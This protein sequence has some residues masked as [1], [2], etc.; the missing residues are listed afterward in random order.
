MIKIENFYGYENAYRSYGNYDHGDPQNWTTV[1]NDAIF[2][3]D[4]FSGLAICQDPFAMD[5]GFPSPRDEELFGVDLDTPVFEQFQAPMV[6]DPPSDSFSQASVP[7]AKADPPAPEFPSDWLLASE[8]YFPQP[9]Q[10]PMTIPPP[11]FI[12]AP[13]P[14]MNGPP[15]PSYF[16]QLPAAA[17]P[18]F[19]FKMFEPIPPAQKMINQSDLFSP[20]VPEE[21]VL[22]SQL[23]THDFDFFYPHAAPSF[24]TTPRLGFDISCTFSAA[25][26]TEIFNQFASR[27]LLEKHPQ[28]N[29]DDFK[30][31]EKTGY[32]YF[33]KNVKTIVPTIGPWKF[34]SHVRTGNGSSDRSYNLVGFPIRCK[35]KE[36]LVGSDLWR[37]YHFVKGKTPKQ[38]AH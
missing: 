31:I 18:S 30:A 23:N 20:I 36:W 14:R 8:K 33:I 35:V 28:L 11:S 26:Y 15:C 17:A 24:R 13:V 3:D 37:C 10:I 1:E 9:A 5:N 34:L 7:V 27:L 6:C 19:P 16:P 22:F 38:R 21:K 2:A 32:I 29:E 25:K 12:P 4:P